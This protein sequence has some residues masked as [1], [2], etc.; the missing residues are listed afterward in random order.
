MARSED[1]VAE[2]ERL[3]GRGVEVV[4][5]KTGMDGSRQGWIEDPDGNAIELMQ[6]VET[7][8]QLRGNS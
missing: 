1:L 2:Q 6:Y 4:R 5:I 8:L 3:A 7:S